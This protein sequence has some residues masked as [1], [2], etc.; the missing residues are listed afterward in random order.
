VVGDSTIWGLGL[1]DEQTLSGQLNSLHLR[2]GGKRVVA[3]NLGYPWPSISR[4]A[5]IIDN[6]MQYQPDLVIWFV[7]VT[8]FYI[9]LYPDTDPHAVFFRLNRQHLEHLTVQFDLNHWF[10]TYVA[11]ES[12]LTT[13]LAVKNQD[14]LPVWMASLEYPFKTYS[15]HPLP[16]PNVEALPQHALFET[17]YPGFYPMPN[18]VWD[19]LQ[20]GNSLT[21]THNAQLLVI[22]QPIRIEE[23]LH[24]E[25]NY[26]KD[27]QRAFYDEYHA[28]LQ[29]QTDAQNIWYADLFDVIPER[30]FLDSLHV[31]AEGMALI[32]NHVVSQLQKRLNTDIRH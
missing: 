15:V 5:L 23:G 20:I 26:N 16:T 9:G 31:D 2:V 8:A 25:V 14:V 29:K 19:F 6:A 4:G 10:E 24:A 28:A 21:I 27:F 18:E 11:K 22:N 32:A 1:T 12:P 17:G 7:T 3:Y 13:M 30:Y